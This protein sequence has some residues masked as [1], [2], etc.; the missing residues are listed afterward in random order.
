MKNEQ[1]L[2]KEVVWTIH[3][4]MK[5]ASFNATEKDTAVLRQIAPNDLGKMSLTR[6]KMTHLTNEAI[7]PFFKT[8]FL[9]D[10]K[11]QYFSL[12]FDETDSANKSKEL[13]ILVKY[14]S[15]SIKKLQ[16]FHLESSF[17]GKATAD[18]LHSKIK[19]AVRLNQLSYNK[20]VMICND[21]PNVNKSVT[22]KVNGEL[23]V[24]RGYGMID[25]GTCV[26]HVLHNAFR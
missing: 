26:V 12:L 19:E 22:R 4:V 10:L 9:D 23:I 18:V 13:G 21:G 6:Q 3:A 11:G 2:E 7:G 8:L 15:P 5:N 1:T 24:D 25:N 16:I 20:L 17:I 14:Y